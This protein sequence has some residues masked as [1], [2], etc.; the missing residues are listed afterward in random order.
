MNIHGRHLELKRQFC[1]TALL[2]M[3]LVLETLPCLCAFSHLPFLCCTYNFRLSRE[4]IWNRS[5]NSSHKRILNRSHRGNF[6]SLHKGIFNCPHGG[7]FLNIFHSFPRAAYKPSS[8][9]LAN[10]IIVHG[11]YTL[12][13]QE[14]RNKDSITSPSSTNHYSAVRPRTSFNLEKNTWNQPIAI[15]M[16]MH[17]LQELQTTKFEHCSLISFG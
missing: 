12:L 6:N 1:A 15:W 4:R 17:T 11:S 2:C 9:F 13:F 10:E 14:C 3:C 7:E 8:V 5:H 16:T